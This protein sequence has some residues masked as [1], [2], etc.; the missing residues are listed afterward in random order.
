ME[1]PHRT[2]VHEALGVVR[3]WHEDEGFGVIDTDETPGGIGA[4]FPVIHMSGFKT[5]AA[6]QTVRV[7]Y[8]P[9]RQDDCAFQS[10]EVLPVEDAD[11]RK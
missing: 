4:V 9:E 11:E 2:L 3:V 7:K 6:G 8:V 1:W 5:L 10:V